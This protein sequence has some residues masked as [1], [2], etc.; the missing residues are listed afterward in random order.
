MEFVNHLMY[1]LV[2][3]PA[4][5]ASWSIAN[6]VVIGVLHGFGDLDRQI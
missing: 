6:D 2:M 4:G 3:G 1:E 5:V